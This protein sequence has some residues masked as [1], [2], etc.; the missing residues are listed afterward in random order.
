MIPLVF[1]EHAGG[2]PTTADGAGP[3]GEEKVTAVMGAMW[4]DRGQ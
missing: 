4:D 1:P 2:V 3:S